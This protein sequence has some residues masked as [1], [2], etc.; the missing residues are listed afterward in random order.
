[1][2]ASMRTNEVVPEPISA[3]LEP[4]W[5]A[6][7]GRAVGDVSRIV[8]AEFQLVELSFRTMIEQEIDRALKAVVALGLLLCG[9]ICAVGAA[10]LGLHHLLGIWWISF[11]IVAAASCLGGI[12]LFAWAMR[13]PTLL[14]TLPVSDGSAS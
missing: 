1:M 6:L 5:P 14:T 13:R 4:G 12:A 7:I 11:A 9:A 8:H 3:E 2:A 10:V